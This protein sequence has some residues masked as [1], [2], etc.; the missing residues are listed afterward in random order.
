MLKW[1]NG[2]KVFE[3][4]NSGDN[5]FHGVIAQSFTNASSYTL[6]TNIEKYDKSALDSILG[7]DIMTYKYKSDVEDDGSNAE[8]HVGVLSEYAPDDITREDKKSVDLYAMVA[9]SWKAIQE[10]SEQVRY[11]KR[12]LNNR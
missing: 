8:M 11:L 2:G 9:L 10:L 5:G 6:K 4:K 7:T 3:F 12:K 1:W